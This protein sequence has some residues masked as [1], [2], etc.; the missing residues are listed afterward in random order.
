MGTIRSPLD[1][2]FLTRYGQEPLKYLVI[3]KSGSMDPISFFIRK[4]YT[5]DLYIIN[6]N[7]I[8]CPSCVPSIKS[9]L[10]RLSIDPVSVE[11]SVTQQSV[12]VTSPP[13]GV[14]RSEMYT[15]LYDAGFDVE[16]EFGDYIQSASHSSL[17]P[18]MFYLRKR[19]RRH[20]RTCNACKSTQSPKSLGTRLTSWIPTTVSRPPDNVDDSSPGI[21]L[22]SN[23]YRVSLSIGGMT[24][25]SCVNAIMDALKD[26]PGVSQ[27]T[28]DLI[29][30]CGSALVTQQEIGREI[31]DT[32]EDIGY[33][34]ELV[35][36]EPVSDVQITSGVYR[37][38]LT[39]AGM[40]CA[41]CESA[42]S[43]SLSSLEFVQAVDVSFLA[44][45]GT[46]TFSPREKITEIK[47]AVEEAGY[48]CD[49]TTLV[50]LGSLAQS[51]RTILLK[52]NGIPE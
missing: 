46:V 33:E 6:L 4:Y 26:K 47:C 25:A 29:G 32:I 41:S 14:S 28:V 34:C 11:V 19:K 2:S 30:K 24:C 31:K 39:I 50:K 13:H 3:L 35:A 52:V 42:I 21:P 16:N 49:V 43:R 1:S 44:H 37:A 10:S 18:A 9:A 5:F 22:E 12:K 45:S 48:E 7:S 8:H 51:S 20:L 36:V 27:M 17:V 23:E 40:T 15:A 38:I